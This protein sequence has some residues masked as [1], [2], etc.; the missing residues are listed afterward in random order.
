MGPAGHSCATVRFDF[1]LVRSTI[2]LTSIGVLIGQR[3]LW[4]DTAAD[5]EKR[6]TK[7]LTHELSLT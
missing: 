6:Y 7:E 4:T 5:K 3:G 2:F 1:L